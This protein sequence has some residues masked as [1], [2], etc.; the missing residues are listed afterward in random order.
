MLNH[1]PLL[2]FYLL[3]FQTVEDEGEYEAEADVVE[4]TE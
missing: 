2:L 1:N 3:N 4:D